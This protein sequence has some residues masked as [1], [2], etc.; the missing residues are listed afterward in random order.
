MAASNCPTQP[1]NNKRRRALELARAAPAA[2]PRRQD[3]ETFAA[4]SGYDYL[5]H[6]TAIPGNR[7]WEFGQTRSQAEGF[8]P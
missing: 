8:G 2:G 7:A 5:K 6:R 3:R 1:S 4:F